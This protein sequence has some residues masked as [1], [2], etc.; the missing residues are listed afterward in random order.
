MGARSARRPSGCVLI[1]HT[2]PPHL[3]I[4]VH[5]TGLTCPWRSAP[6]TP[7]MVFR[8]IWRPWQSRGESLSWAREERLRESREQLLLEG[9]VL[10]EYPFD[11]AP[12]GHNVTATRPYDGF[13]E[14]DSRPRRLSKVLHQLLERSGT[15]AEGLEGNLGPRACRLCC[16][17]RACRGRTRSST[18]ARSESSLGSDALAGIERPWPGRRGRIPPERLKSARGCRRASQSW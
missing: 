7:A 8:R 15:R 10:L 2:Q 4:R 17:V 16:S 3:V 18:R 12:A 9:T 5:V 6:V 14:P 11:A 13:R 1:V